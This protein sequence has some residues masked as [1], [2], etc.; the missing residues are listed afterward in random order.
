MFMDEVGEGCNVDDAQQRISWRFHMHQPRTRGN[1]LTKIN[2][3]CCI[4]VTN[5]NSAAV[6]YLREESIAAAIKII[7]GEDLIS[8]P[9]QPCDR[10]NRSD[11][12]R[13]AEGTMRVFKL[14]ELLL[15]YATC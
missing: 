1:R 11:A 5:V 14:G 12:T 10:G 9:Q 15:E 13:K 6:E 2:E 4:A 7:A 3:I 8:G